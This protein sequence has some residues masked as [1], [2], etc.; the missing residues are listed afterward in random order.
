MYDTDT[1]SCPRIRL[2]E[3]V[4]LIIRPR[5]PGTWLPSNLPETIPKFVWTKT[6]RC[7]WLS[8]RRSF[9]QIHTAGAIEPIS[10]ATTIL[11]MNNW[12]AVTDVNQ[13]TNVV[14]SSLENLAPRSMRDT[15]DAT[16]T[17]T[18]VARRDF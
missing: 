3:E 11:S 15:T 7:V 16:A 1:R 8:I 13:H 2:F 9:T 17:E 6:L 5:I 10:D 18:R 12:T 4:I 14:E